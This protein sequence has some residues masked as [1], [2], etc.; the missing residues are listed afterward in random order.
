MKIEK[1]GEVSV[2]SKRAGWILVVKSG[3]VFSIG[4]LT[5]FFIPSAIFVSS[6]KFVPWSFPDNYSGISDFFPFE[7]DLNWKPAIGD[8]AEIYTG[9]DFGATFLA[10]DLPSYRAMLKSVR[11][12]AKKEVNRLLG[13]GLIHR[14]PSRSSLTVV[15]TH[16]DILQADETPYLEVEMKNQDGKT[17]KGFVPRA[18]VMRNSIRKFA[19]PL[20]NERINP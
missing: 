7:P 6:P 10:T 18:D 9:G 14:V 1:S 4:I 2:T 13:A 11:T 20:A 5:F 12:N 19:G 17:L 8:S 15:E 16:S 3:I